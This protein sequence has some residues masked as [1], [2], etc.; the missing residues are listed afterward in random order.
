MPRNRSVAPPLHTQNDTCVKHGMSGNVARAGYKSR[1]KR[2]TTRNEIQSEKRVM[3]LKI[4]PYCPS[5]ITKQSRFSHAD[6]TIPT[7]YAEHVLKDTL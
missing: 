6:S 7:T 3:S 4:A 5:D 2:N 1:T